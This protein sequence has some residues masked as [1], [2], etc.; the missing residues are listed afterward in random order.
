MAI[1]QAVTTSFKS[2][3]LQAIHLRLL[4]TLQVLL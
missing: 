4:F 2:E 3:L 1:T